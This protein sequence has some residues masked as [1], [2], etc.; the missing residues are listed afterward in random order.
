M[1]YFHTDLP[2]KQAGKE[3]KTVY[4]YVFRH[5]YKGGASGEEVVVLDEVLQLGEVPRVP[6]P[7]AH[8]EGVEVLVHLVELR[9]GLDDHVVRATRVELDLHNIEKSSHN[10]DYACRT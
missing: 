1:V 4:N 8:G 9:D 10:V 7:H 5:L 3:E 6:L 2:Q